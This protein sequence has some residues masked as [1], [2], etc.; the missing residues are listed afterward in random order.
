MVDADA[1]AVVETLGCFTAAVSA[2]TDGCDAE[3]PA[4]LVADAAGAA[5][6]AGLVEAGWTA[7]GLLMDS[8]LSFE[9]PP[10]LPSSSGDA[11]FRLPAVVAGL[12]ALESAAVLL[13]AAASPSMASKES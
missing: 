4:A 12:A 13:W 3:E 6:E 10:S 9:Y 5:V 2:E 8:K 11:L 1:A 7:T